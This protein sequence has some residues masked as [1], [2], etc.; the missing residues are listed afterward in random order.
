MPSRF[1]AVLAE[2]A[3][4]AL[5]G[6]VLAWAC[7][8]LSP[9][10]LVLT[11]NYFPG[12][13]RPPKVMSLATN[14]SPVGATDNPATSPADS[15]AARLR[16]RQLRVVDRAGMET[17]FRDPRRAQGLVVIVDARDDA[18]YQ[19]GHIPG[20]HQLDHYR[21]PAYLPSVLPVCLNAEAV[22]VYCHGGDCE[23]AEFAAT[24]LHEAGV[25]LE[26]LAV[27]VG[28]FSEW[29]TNNLPVERGVHRGSPAVG[30]VR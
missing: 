29:A 25:P 2:G 12:A 23:D 3:V 30:E 15:V 20:A 26:R 22:V 19:A 6:V 27:Y 10:G 21:A 1:K 7:N 14:T 16:A 5:G 28:G 13:V 18:H 9:R 8:A 4:V 24:L 17:L 11:R